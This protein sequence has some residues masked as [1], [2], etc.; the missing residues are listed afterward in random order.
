MDYEKNKKSREWKGM[1]KAVPFF[2]ERKH[3]EICKENI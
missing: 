3:Y 1:A 2:L